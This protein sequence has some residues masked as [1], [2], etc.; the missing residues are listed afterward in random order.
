MGSLE[1]GPDYQ[2]RLTTADGT[3]SRRAPPPRYDWADPRY[4]VVHA[5]GVPCN[6][7]ILA[8]LRGKGEAETTGEDNLQTMRLVYGAY[9]SAARGGALVRP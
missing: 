6:A 2:V 4:D 7:S 3:H 8:A 5:S 9:D 1:L